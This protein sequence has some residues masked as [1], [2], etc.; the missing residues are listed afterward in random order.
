MTKEEKDEKDELLE[1]YKLIINARNFHYDNF[2]KWMT[3][4]YVAIGALFI[5]YCTI[6]GSVKIVD[7]KKEMLEYAILLLGYFVSI[8]W[9]WSSKGYYYWNINFI[10]LINHYE[11]DLMKLIDKDRVYF[12]FA[13]KEREN[14]YLNPIKGANIST[15]K[16]TILFAFV[17][18]SM[19][20]FLL[21]YSYLLTSDLF[22][23]K[24]FVTFIISLFAII[25]FNLFLSFIPSLFLKS[26]IDKMPDLKL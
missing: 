10:T 26:N 8:L 20:G 9:Y 23:P 19:W 6:V 17:V 18:T 21:L 24:S 5:G 16:I 4:F 3:F 22:E 25:G 14:N 7:D 15:S 13:N 2:S 1:R 11:E 12:V